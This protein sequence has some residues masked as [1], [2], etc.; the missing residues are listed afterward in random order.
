MVKNLRSSY[1]ITLRDIPFVKH[2]FKKTTQE[3]INVLY[4]IYFSIDA[5]CKENYEIYDFVQ[6]TR[7]PLTVH[8]L[9][10]YNFIEIRILL[11]S[12]KCHFDTRVWGRRLFTDGH[13]NSGSRRTNC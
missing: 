3:F 12:Y 4:C 1:L 7:L 5:K 6:V 9:R 8:I 11:S 10:K 2:G 13:S